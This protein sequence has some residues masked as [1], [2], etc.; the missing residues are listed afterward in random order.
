MS[1]PD[2]KTS[3]GSDEYIDFKEGASG[4]LKDVNIV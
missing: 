2:L 3:E 1:I 4:L